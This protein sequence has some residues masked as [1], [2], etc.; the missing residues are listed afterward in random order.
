MAGK[1][2]VQV[3]DLTGKKPTHVRRFTVNLDGAS[4]VFLI[5][6]QLKRHLVSKKKAKK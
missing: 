5:E 4:T 6:K 2:T 3:I 1:A